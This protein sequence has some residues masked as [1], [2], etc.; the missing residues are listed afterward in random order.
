MG[1]NIAN[2]GLQTI[3]YI[4]DDARETLNHESTARQLVKRT[5]KWTGSHIEG[6]V[7]VR[8]SGALNWAEDGGQLPAANKQSYVP[9]KSYRKFLHGTIQLTDGSMAA[10]QKPNAARDA[11]TSEVKGI[12]RD[13]MKAENGMFFRD[14]TGSVGQLASNALASSSSDVPV[15]DARLLWE[16]VSYDVYN[17][18]GGAPSTTKRGT[19]EVSSVESAPSGDNFLVNFASTVSGATTNDHLVWKN[20]VNRCVTGLDK[21]IGDSGTFQNINTATYPRYTSLVMG[22]SGTN[23]PLTPTLFRQMLAGLYMKTGRKPRGLKVI[24]TSWGLIEVEELYEGDLRLSPSDTTHGLEHAAFQSALGRISIVPDT[25]ALYNKIFFVDTD[26]I[27]RATQRKLGWR[28]HAG[29]LLMPSQTAAVWTGTIIEIS[30]Y[31]IEQ[32]HSSGKLEDIEETRVTA[33]N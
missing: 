11:L 21:L 16:G 20:S 27:V 2:A 14:G 15:T 29:Q 26:E 5:K 10:V 22:N 17:N 12:M 30:E 3:N 24:A 28:R 32:R 31:F 7:H 25:D 23:R 18:S 4:I 13:I 33:F 8:R 6:R 9:F 19:V 1:L